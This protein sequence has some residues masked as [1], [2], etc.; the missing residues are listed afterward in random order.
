MDEF[1]D[2]KYKID[3]LIYYNQKMIDANLLI[4]ENIEDLEEAIQAMNDCQKL[5]SD[6]FSI[7]VNKIILRRKE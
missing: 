7:L 5:Q 1:H 6:Q 3:Q 4:A 2:V